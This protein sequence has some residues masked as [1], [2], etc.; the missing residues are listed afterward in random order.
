MNLRKDLKCEGMFCSFTFRSMMRKQELGGN[1][2]LGE[3]PH[4]GGYPTILLSVA[5][6]SS[7]GHQSEKETWNNQAKSYEPQKVEVLDVVQAQPSQKL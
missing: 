3:R 1:T 4:C 7:I 2:Q 5:F 6:L